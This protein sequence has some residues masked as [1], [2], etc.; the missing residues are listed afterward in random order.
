MNLHRALLDYDPVLLAAI[1]E[2]RGVE[3]TATQ[4]RDIAEQ[5][6]AALLDSESV[7]QV[8]TWLPPLQRAALDALLIAGGRLPAA[9]F[10]RDH[11]AVRRMGPGR[12]EREKP[13]RDPQSPSEALYFA[14]LL[15][16]G[17]DQVEGQITESVFLPDDVLSLLPPVQASTEGFSVVTLPS[18]RIV[19][20]TGRAIA[21][22]LTTLLA[23]VETDS[24][25]PQRDRTL[26]PRDLAR[27]NER[28]MAPQDL[29][30]VR[31]EIEADRLAL[32]L[33]LA[34]RLRLIDFSGRQLRVHRPETRE[35][36]Q[37]DRPSQMLTLQQAWRDDAG[38]NDLQHVPS[39]HLER[40]GWRN[41]PVSTRTRLLE[42]LAQCP[43]SEWIGLESF[44]AAVKRTDPDFQRPPDAYN[45]WYIR[46]ADSGD[47]LMGYEHWDRVEGALIAYLIGGPLHWLG[48]TALGLKG[49]EEA[50]AFR[51][52]PGGAFFLELTDRIPEAPRLPPMAV[53]AD[54][55]V[56]ALAGGNLYDRFQL[57]RI[58]EW[59]ASGEVFIYRITH[60]SL[61]RALSQ[62]IRVEQV[63]TFLKR[64]TGDRL[65]PKAAETLR[66]WAGRYGEVRL[67]RTA[68]L[69]TKTAAIMQELRAHPAIGPLLSEPLSPTR[70]LVAE[71]N[72][73]R[74]LTLLQE[75]GYLPER[76]GRISN[77]TR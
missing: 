34:R 57:A 74:L 31:Q 62:G 3:L 61:N 60:T 5:L 18:P 56:R 42:H 45:T 75:A 52:T 69:E 59:R 12:L 40:T 21:E 73:R 51:L 38:W 4:Q 29:S 70:T 1:A 23:W 26:H 46:H 71:Q 50:V 2:R 49:Q 47:Y 63:L 55:T 14:G 44:V 72:W 27:I 33:C 24:P 54:L 58:A 48:V 64:V 22:D 28:L 19:R 8:V 53:D 77:D 41:D 9:R 11:G 17:F 43:S 6:A 67:I 66:G 37:A 30:G 16:F 36:L 10:C 35:W 25:R 65:P 32:L 7:N 39:L 68:V 15:F 13:W 20:D 76:K